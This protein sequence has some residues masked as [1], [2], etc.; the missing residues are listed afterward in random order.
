MQGA[1]N[2]NARRTISAE[3]R[4]SYSRGLTGSLFAA[5]VL[6]LSPTASWAFDPGAE[7]PAAPDQFTW[8]ANAR[9]PKA[10]EW[11]AEQSK[12]T[13]KRLT[14]SSEF[15]KVEAEI[16]DARAASSPKP[17]Y[18]LLQDKVV[19][20]VRNSEHRAGAFYVAP[21]SAVTK[22]GAIDWRLALDV[23]A[24]NARESKR[25][26]VMF[27]NLNVQCMPQKDR[28]LIPFGDGGSSLVEYREFDFSAGRFV[29]G[30][31]HSPPTRGDFGWLNPDTILIGYI[32]KPSDR[33][34][35]GF[36]QTIVAWKRGTPI[37]E[38]KPVYS[39]KSTDSMVSATTIGT[40]PSQQVLLNRVLDYSN[41][42]LLVVG[43][44]GAVER[45]DL[46]TKMQNFGTAFVTGSK[47][48]VQL[49]DAAVIEGRTYA[50]DT[51]VSYDPTE[52]A[53]RR[54][55]EVFAPKAGSYVNDPFEGIAG[56]ADG[57]AFVETRN[58]QKTLLIA[59]PSARGWT[60][61]RS[62]T[63]APGVAMTIPSYDRFGSG[64]IVE[65][66]GF[67]TPTEIKLVVPGRKPAALFKGKAV[68]DARKFVTEIRSARSRDGTMVDYYLVRP[69]ERQAGPTPVILAGYGG[70]GINVE[71]SYFTGDLGL[72]LVS[73]LNRGGAF[74]RAAIRGGGERG[75][76]W[77][78]AAK[79][80][81]RQLSYDDFAAVAEDM[82]KSGLTAPR[83]IGSFG[84]S[85]GGLLSANMVTQQPELFGASI[86][87]VPVTDLFR[88]VD[89]GSIIDAG[90]VSETGDPKDPKQASI[91]LG[92]SPYQN[93]RTGVNYP[94]VLTVVSTEDGQ[95][96]PGYGRR[97]AAKLQSVGA[98]SLLLEGPTG[99]HGFPNEFA[100]PK[101]HA[102]QVTFFIES[103]M[104]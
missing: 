29:E 98:D 103:L 90:G 92:Y 47:L 4:Y 61:T 65:Q 68:V 12:K 11:A 102:A 58:L 57:L 51:L 38:A 22:G 17:S 69:K 84:R 56:T 5:S 78:N 9:D 50:A 80:I 82:V 3:G 96:G 2:Q 41:F 21:R 88:G 6:A 60:I 15:A 39:A 48:V 89:D 64:L 26:E 52:P 91:M 104:K 77:T 34:D 54:V 55:T 75:S 85:F 87:G 86:V 7:D 24:L 72:G 19:R 33:L 13:M 101:E 76:A 46:P 14:A 16:R 94:H 42:E 25:Y 81:N 93:I 44:D 49:A 37:A 53:G 100:N 20:F 32:G 71:P 66:T 36:A 67:L 1:T 63:A 31:F 43:Q 73:W 30:G 95:V 83:K 70:Y 74:S 28:C 45:L 8:L 59:R 35:S 40:G 27:L 79:G 99:G 23:D 10:L 62:L 97:F 18:Y